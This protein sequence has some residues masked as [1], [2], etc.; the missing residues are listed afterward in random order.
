MSNAAFSKA[1][2]IM[3]TLTE[4]G[5]PMPMEELEQRVAMKRLSLEKLVNMLQFHGW[6]ARDAETISI[7]PLVRGW[8][9]SAISIDT[10]PERAAPHLTAVQQSTGFDCGLSIFSAPNTVFVKKQGFTKHANA[11][12]LGVPYEAH[13]VPSGRAVLATYPRSYLDSYIAQFL[14]D[15]P[16]DWIE[17][18]VKSPAE[19]TKIRGYGMTSG[20]Q[21]TLI[22]AVAVPI[23]D[24][25]NEA[26]GAIN[27]WR[28]TAEPVGRPSDYLLDNVGQLQRAA[29]QISGALGASRTAI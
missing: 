23:F 9:L 24:A 27:L 2:T 11:P 13:L 21:V 3:R 22:E 5:V 6:V 14:S 16:D 8:G 20:D 12:V 29:V 1:N 25:G 4:A 18:F 28:P 10:L 19:D 26:I 17:E 15:K 7:G